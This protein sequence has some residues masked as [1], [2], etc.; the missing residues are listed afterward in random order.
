MSRL[1]MAPGP[2]WPHGSSCADIIY[3]DNGS[4]ATAPNPDP[5]R[6]QS[7]FTTVT[8]MKNTILLQHWLDTARQGKEQSQK[9]VDHGL[10][11]STY[12]YTVLSIIL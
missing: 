9:R 3:D 1:S 5:H 11:R 10:D 8:K 7:K 12:I 2:S 6:T 4:R